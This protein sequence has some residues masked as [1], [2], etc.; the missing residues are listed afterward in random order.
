M[1]AQRNQVICPLPHSPSVMDGNLNLGSLFPATLLTLIGYFYTGLI[2]P[3]KKE[4]E[5]HLT[6]PYKLS[7]GTHTYTKNTHAYIHMYVHVS[8]SVCMCA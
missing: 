8:V 5:C 1:E 6:L 3:K 4:V 2:F 7:W